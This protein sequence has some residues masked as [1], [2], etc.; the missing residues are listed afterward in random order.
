MVNSAL[1]D[2]WTPERVRALSGDATA[3]PLPLQRL[4]VVEWAGQAGDETPPS[5]MIIDFQGLCLVRATGDDDR[6]VGQLDSD[7][8]VIR[9]SSY[10]S[11]LGEAVRGR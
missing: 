1:P 6:Y 5:E 3:A 8:S 4:V 2:G 9:C 7:G 11:D 10:G